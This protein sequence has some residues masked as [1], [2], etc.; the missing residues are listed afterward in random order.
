M[1]RIDFQRIQ[2]L[3]SLN[4]RKEVAFKYERKPMLV[5][6]PVIFYQTLIC[7]SFYGCK[8]V[9]T[10]T[11]LEFKWEIMSQLTALL[12]PLNHSS[13]VMDA[14]LATVSGNKSS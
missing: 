8:K 1:T 11:Q 13:A 3:R 9:R 4:S 2:I 10:Q 7:A 5:T 6:K 14:S 12:D